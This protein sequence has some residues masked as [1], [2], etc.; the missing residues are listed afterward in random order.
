MIGYVGYDVTE[1]ET[2]LKDAREKALMYYNR[3]RDRNFELESDECEFLTE[4]QRFERRLLG[5]ILDHLNDAF[6]SMV[7]LKILLNQN[8]KKD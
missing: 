2:M 6:G 1:L 7:S 3:V 8:Q 5:C 4:D